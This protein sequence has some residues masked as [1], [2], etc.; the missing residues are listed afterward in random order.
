MG[1]DKT[2]IYIILAIG[3]IL[4][5]W[6]INH[7]LPEINR[8]IFETDEQHLL[9]ISM[10]FGTGDLNPH[11]FP[12]PGFYLY[13]VFL[14]FGSF[15]AMGRLFG[16]FHS[17]VDFVGYYFTDPTVFYILAR[18]LNVIFGVL[19]IYF[20]Y[21]L[22]EKIFNKD[23]GRMAALLLSVTPVHVFYSHIVKTDTLAALLSLLCVY[24]SF[25]I[26]SDGSIKS[27]VK[28][29]LFAGL[30]LGTRYP[31]G[32]IIL[33]VICA[34]LMREKRGI[35]TYRG[36]KIM[37]AI[38]FFFVAGF[39]IVSPYNFLD[40]KNFIQQE[41]SANAVLTSGALK[42]DW[43]VQHFIDT[44]HR[45]QIGIILTLLAIAAV[46]RSFYKRTQADILLN[47][48]W[49]PVFLFFSLPKWYLAP[50]QYMLNIFPIWMLLIARLI[51][52]A[53]DKFKLSATVL[54]AS[55]L[56]CIILSVL[57]VAKNNL[58]LSAGLTTQRAKYWVEKNIP[59]KS[60]I[61]MNFAE[62]PQLTLVPEAYIRFRQIVNGSVERDKF[63]GVRW[64]FVPGRL[65]REKNKLMEL[66]EKSLTKGKQYNV[67]FY[68]QL[69]AKTADPEN[70]E[71]TLKKYN[72]EYVIA[73]LM[74]EE[75]LP[76]L[77]SPYLEP[78]QKF[79]ADKWI[80]FLLYDIAIFRVKK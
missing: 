29:S 22:G 11:S 10:A 72:I 68:E 62:T 2:I 42:Y 32:I 56:C 17:A 69:S 60:V 54:I 77:G 53:L 63:A 70:F 59:E 34:F 1:K 33:A 47:M 20:V 9:N 12:Q 30:T 16:F 71:S 52:D 38:L 6:G 39:F 67:Y 50:P 51:W 35:F 13:L 3:L 78:L 7:G 55:V 27:Y 18:G 26:L 21:K 80:P 19:T 73:S 4:R 79:Y 40:W 45:N 46:L 37:V 31:Q 41:I 74:L 25:D 44:A 8:Y 24:F 48:A 49:L 43:I 28:A 23:T 64:D 15:Y 76:A 57:T 75:K 66:K 61:L 65:N 58:A 14:L 5:I 36:L